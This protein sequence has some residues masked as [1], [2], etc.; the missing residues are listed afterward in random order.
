MLDNSKQHNNTLIEDTHNYTYSCYTAITAA[1]TV[2]ILTHHTSSLGRIV[3]Q[4][5]LQSTDHDQLHVH[6]Y[7][8]CGSIIT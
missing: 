1:V 5:A 3:S 4:P 2:I 7:I 6:S 8:D